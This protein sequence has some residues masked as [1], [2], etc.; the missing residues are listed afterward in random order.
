MVDK[1]IGPAR[2]KTDNNANQRPNFAYASANPSPQ[3]KLDEHVSQSAADIQMMSHQ[4]SKPCLTL[5][6]NSDFH[7]TLL[8]AASFHSHCTPYIEKIRKCTRMKNL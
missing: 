4:M 7:D 8:V 3:P 5:P 1:C 2:P 6:C